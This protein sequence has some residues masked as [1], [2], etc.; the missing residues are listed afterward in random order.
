[1]SEEI[2]AIIISSVLSTI[3]LIIS[4][5]TFI[6]NKPKIKIELT[7]KD[8]DA[9]FGKV[10]LK[11]DKT[12]PTLIGFV[13]LNIINNSPV[14]ISIK[15]IKLKVGK[16]YHRLIDKNNSYWHDCYFYYLDESGE[17]VWD[18]CGINYDE[19]GIVIPNKIKAYSILSGSCLFYHY[20][21]IDSSHKKCKIVLYT[22]VG[23][24][25]KRINMKKYD[26]KYISSEMK[27]VEL[28]QKNEITK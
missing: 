21:I 6:I 12:S 8:C 10:R 11:N 15:D 26:E 5:K 2:I 19:C 28:F 3:S 1:M 17:D 20:P 9:Y 13:E 25:T 16:T 18:G 7:D 24:I 14:D 23:K 27:D 22:A 4:I